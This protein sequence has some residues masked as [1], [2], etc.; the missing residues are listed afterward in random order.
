MNIIKFIH[1][2][3][4]FFCF[5]YNPIAQCNSNSSRY[6]Q[7]NLELRSNNNKNQTNKNSKVAVNSVNNKR[8]LSREI[9]CAKPKRKTYRVV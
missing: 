3:I 9:I 4:I 5:L 6:R 8:T 7:N 1:I 2:L